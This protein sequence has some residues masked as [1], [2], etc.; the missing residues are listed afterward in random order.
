MLL[1]TSR[2][3]FGIEINPPLNVNFFPLVVNVIKLYPG[4]CSRV[5]LTWK[6]GRRKRDP[7]RGTDVL[8]LII[9]GIYSP[10]HKSDSIDR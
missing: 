9:A 5:H 8:Q 6:G 10:Q 1:A 2:S 3:Y 4:S 7:E